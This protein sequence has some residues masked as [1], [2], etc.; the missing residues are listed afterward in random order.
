MEARAGTRLKLG[1]IPHMDTISHM[2]RLER[3]PLLDELGADR[4]PLVSAE[5]RGAMRLPVEL[6]VQPIVADRPLPCVSTDLSL[7]GIRLEGRFAGDDGSPFVQ[8]ELPLPGSPEPVWA[9]GRVVYQRLGA[10]FPETGIRFTRMATGDRRR[11]AAWLRAQRTALGV[12]AVVRDHGV[13][14][15]RP[16]HAASG[17]AIMRRP[18]GVGSL[19]RP[20]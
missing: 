9:R 4:D 20:M 7:R 10:L 11:L 3:T 19:A 8:L 14:I 16:A 6:A 12:G 5:R 15:V 18:D 13:A 17:R 2:T 1:D